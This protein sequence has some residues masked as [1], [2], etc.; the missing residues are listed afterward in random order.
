MLTT[1]SKPGFL[2]RMTWLPRRSELQYA[3]PCRQ[4]G[5]GG[6]T[7]KTDLSNEMFV[8]KKAVSQVNVCNV[9]RR[10]EGGGNFSDGARYEGAE[11]LL[12]VPVVIAEFEVVVNELQT[13]PNQV[14]GNHR[15]A[16]AP[17]K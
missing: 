12:G 15:A 2:S 16:L 10:F 5:G 7:L 3:R 1:V 6:I 8:W 4:Q 9:P 14:E 17:P 13:E 11:E